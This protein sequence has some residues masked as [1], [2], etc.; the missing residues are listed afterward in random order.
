MLRGS[1]SCNRKSCGRAHARRMKSATAARSHSLK[2]SAARFSFLLSSFLEL[3]K[4]FSPFQ[5]VLFFFRFPSLPLLIF[6]FF[7]V[8]FF[9]L[10]FSS[11]VSFDLYGK[12]IFCFTFIVLTLFNY[13]IEASK[14]VSSF[15]IWF[16]F[17][18][19]VRSLLPSFIVSNYTYLLI[20]A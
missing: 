8:R 7:F 16:S 11:Y 4:Y 2:N 6:F 14:I 20:Y 17:F 10:I 12:E 1:I 3:S 18:G 13:T 15:C 9:P 19:L 5:F